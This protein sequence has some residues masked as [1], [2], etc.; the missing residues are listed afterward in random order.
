MLISVI[1]PVYNVA[2]YLPECI[3][4]IINQSYRNLEIILVNDGSTDNS[5]KICYKYSKL[6]KRIKVYS[7]VNSG[8]GLT[9][10][11]GIKHAT[12]NYI[13]FVDSDDY[14][15]NNAIEDLVSSLDDNYA[16]VCIGGY[17][18]VLDNSKILYIEEYDKEFVYKDRIL[19]F[20]IKMLGSLPNKS[21]SIRPSVW[22]CLYNKKLIDENNLSFVSEREIISEDIAWDLDIYPYVNSINIISNSTY[23]YRYNQVS[24]SQ[25][26]KK[27][28]FEECKKLYCYI[29]NKT[30]EYNN[31]EIILRAG[32]Q[33]FVQLHQC[34]SQEKKHINN[35]T[36]K[37]CKNRIK[38]MCED[39]MVIDIINAYPLSKLHIR[40]FIFI[41][42]VKYKVISL[43]YIIV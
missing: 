24:L 41:Q 16:D 17:K 25:K 38:E 34:I 30:K 3:E 29:L 27:E 15:E 20:M 33:F 9:R 35:L 22:N 43:L 6:D 42:L 2:Q 12:G 4:S 26:Y 28:R 40:Q 37:E 13:T 8:L 31:N 23:C 32:K 5:L 21:D 1:I 7:K 18:R 39:K 36:T 10:N 19:N 14:L 11:Y